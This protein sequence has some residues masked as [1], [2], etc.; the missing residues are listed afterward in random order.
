MRLIAQGTEGTVTLILLMYFSVAPDAIQTHVK[1][2]R[3][4]IKN[5]HYIAPEYGSKLMLYF[6]FKKIF[7]DCLL[8]VF[9]ILS[10]YNQ[11]L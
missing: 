11:N 7:Y 4:D 6:R 5:M 1:T 10:R 9:Y 2:C 3:G 8:F